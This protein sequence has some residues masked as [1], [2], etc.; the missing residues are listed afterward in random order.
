M[1]SLVV[2]GSSHVRRLG[3][4]HRRQRRLEIRTGQE[5]AD[6]RLL[7]ADI[8]FVG[9]GGLRSDDC[10]CWPLLERVAE[11]QPA[12][13]VI[14]LGGNDLERGCSAEDV[15]ERL[16]NIRAYLL[17]QGVRWVRIAR[18]AMRGGTRFCPYSLYMTLRQEVNEE[19]GSLLGPACFDLN[20]KWRFPHHYDQRLVH[21]SEYGMAMQLRTLGLCVQAISARGGPF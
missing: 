8:E 14:V 1:A 7:P 16:M 2:F 9:R 19:L 13:V 20:S 15:V 5:N 4:Y 21:A 17:S 6:L 3:E 12:A 18:I 10:H 11:L